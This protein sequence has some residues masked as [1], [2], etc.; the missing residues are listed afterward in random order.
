MERPRDRR[1]RMMRRPPT[2]FMRVRKPVNRLRFV[3]L[4][5]N[6]TLVIVVLVFS[7]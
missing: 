1:R 3:L 4:F 2:V 6:L 7:A 5:R